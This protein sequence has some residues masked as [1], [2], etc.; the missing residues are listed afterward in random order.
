MWGILGIQ[1]MFFY[2]LLLL[3][4]HNHNIHM[5]FVSF[6][7]PLISLQGGNVF[8][9]K[10]H[11]IYIIISYFKNEESFSRKGEGFWKLTHGFL[12]FVPLKLFYLPTMEILNHNFTYI[13]WF[14]TVGF[15]FHRWRTL[16]FH[17]K[18]FLVHMLQNVAKHSPIGCQMKP[19][20]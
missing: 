3:H 17:S 12:I 14:G 16:K 15:T 13:V 7:L 20:P 19:A 10:F 5:C 9:M 18:M 1:V 2:F 4:N 6:P 8:W 11:G